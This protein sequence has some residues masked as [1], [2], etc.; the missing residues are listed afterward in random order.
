MKLQCG[1]ETVGKS[2]YERE[3]G[4]RLS[5]QWYL[6]VTYVPGD[7]LLIMASALRIFIVPAHAGEE[8]E[9]LEVWSQTSAWRGLC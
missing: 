5:N 9:T 2:I 7:Q 4:G 1:L 3:G 6:L 8:M